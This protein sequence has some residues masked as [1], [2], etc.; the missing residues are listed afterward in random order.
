M[1]KVWRG[2]RERCVRLARARDANA[3]IGP[4]AL[5]FIFSFPR[6]PSPGGWPVLSRDIGRRSFGIRRELVFYGTDSH[7]QR[8]FH[9]TACRSSRLLASLLIVGPSMHASGPTAARE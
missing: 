7:L 4:T 3:G 2:H 9:T 1:G 5:P 6:W 8:H